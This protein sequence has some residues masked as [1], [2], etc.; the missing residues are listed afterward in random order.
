MGSDYDVD[1]I[2]VRNSVLHSQYQNASLRVS[3]DAREQAVKG[4]VF[5]DCNCDAFPS[6]KSSWIDFNSKAKIMDDEQDLVSASSSATTTSSSSSSEY[7]TDES[8]EELPTVEK[9][10]KQRLLA[11][12]LKLQYSVNERIYAEGFFVDV[13]DDKIVILDISEKHLI[14]AGTED[15]VD[16]GAM[17]PLAFITVAVAH[18]E[19]RILKVTSCTEKVRIFR[20]CEP[21]DDADEIWEEFTK[22]IELKELSKKFTGKFKLQ[23]DDTVSMESVSILA[24][25]I[26]FVSDQ[27]SCGDPGT[28]KQSWWTDGFTTPKHRDIEE[29]LKELVSREK[30]TEIENEEKKKKEMSVGKLYDRVHDHHFEMDKAVGNLAQPSRYTSAAKSHSCHSNI[31][32]WSTSS[33]HHASTSKTFADSHVPVAT[34]NKKKPKKW[35]KILIPRSVRFQL[36]TR[37][38]AKSPS[39]LSYCIS[40]AEYD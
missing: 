23:D 31:S 9:E 14:V 13:A 11:K 1:A 27:N 29:H 10:Q 35:K 20:F 5:N 26:G 36:K 3:I 2:I 34:D 25:Y 33:A 28:E 21:E 40:N 17:I 6:V 15:D 7:S 18:L 4:K 39:L 24:N 19:K 8:T 12:L 30:K 37:N 16:L 38:A 22:V 32:D